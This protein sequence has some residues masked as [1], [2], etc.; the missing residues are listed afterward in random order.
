[1]NNT[2]VSLSRLSCLSV[3]FWML[4]SVTGVVSAAQAAP[5]PLTVC[6]AGA[7][8][9]KLAQF[10]TVVDCKID[11]QSQLHKFT[12]TGTANSEVLLTLVDMTGVRWGILA[13]WQIC[14]RRGARRLSRRW[15]RARFRKEVLLPATGIYTIRVYEYGDDQLENYRIGL[16]RLFPTSETAISLPIGDVGSGTQDINPVPDQDFYTF[17]AY[18]DGVV[19]LRLNDLTGGCGAIILARW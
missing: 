13:R 2:K 19:T 8:N 4:L 12:F 10:G 6:P 7:N 15:D 14:T 18:K 1:M 16:E 17:H 9:M 3:L 11:A 5:E